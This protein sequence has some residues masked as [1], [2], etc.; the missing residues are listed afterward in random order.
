MTKVQSRRKFVLSGGGALA[1][2]VAVPLI[3][4]PGGCSVSPVSVLTALIA[5][6]SAA[7]TGLVN[8]GL[9][10]AGAVVWITAASKFVTDITAELSSTDSVLTKIAKS[11]AL[12]EADLGALPL[13]IPGEV[14]II[15]NVVIMALNAVVAFL[16]ANQPTTGITS[17]AINPRRAPAKAIGSINMWLPAKLSSSDKA[18]LTQVAADQ[19]AVQA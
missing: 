19:K 18:I 2:G 9:V 11:L 6:L 14:G 10:P 7:I 16:R 4:A 1:A 12:Y 3:L 8:A 13:P 15:I 5:A 17:A